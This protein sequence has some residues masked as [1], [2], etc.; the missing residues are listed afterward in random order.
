MSYYGLMTEDLFQLE[1]LGIPYSFSGNL[2]EIVRETEDQYDF[3]RINKKRI[4]WS[5]PKDFITRIDH[6]TKGLKNEEL[7]IL[8][9][10]GDAS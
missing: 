9:K 7:L 10:G 2:V 5:C 6:T 8:L 4:P 1:E 3:R